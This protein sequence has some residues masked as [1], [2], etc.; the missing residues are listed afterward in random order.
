M[1]QIFLNVYIGSTGE[2]PDT[3]MP[4]YSHV[5][6]SLIYSIELDGDR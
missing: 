4:S 6:G 5:L 2:K 3:D 1:Y